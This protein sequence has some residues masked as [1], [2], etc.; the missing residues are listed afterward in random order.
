M[1]PLIHT[2]LFQLATSLADGMLTII[3]AFF[4]QFSTSL[5]YWVV[6]II[7]TSLFQLFTC[8][9]IRM[10]SAI[11]TLADRLGAD[12]TGLYSWCSRFGCRYSPLLGCGLCLFRRL[13]RLLRRFCLLLW[14]RVLALILTLGNHFSAC[15][16]FLTRYST[17]S[18]HIYRDETQEE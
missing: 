13:L 8:W 7:I 5:T 9:A 16:A 4:L 2:F 6:S 15:L 10:L 18:H 11:V 3:F 17:L 12:F 14:L 1:L